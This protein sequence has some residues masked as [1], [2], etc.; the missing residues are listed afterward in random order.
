M[1]SLFSRTLHADVK[2]YQS[3]DLPY[4]GVYTGVEGFL[5]W[6][7]EMAEYFRRDLKGWRG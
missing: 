5:A 6:S 3:P 7:K 2:L 4:G 1:V